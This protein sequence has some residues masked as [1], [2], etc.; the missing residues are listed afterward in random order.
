MENPDQ[1]KRP[2]MTMLAVILAAGFIIGSLIISSTWKYVSRSSITVNV[3]GSASE[4][5]ISDLAVW[6]GSFS[7]EAGT[8]KDAYARL[9]D[10]NSKVTSYLVSKGFPADK[11][12]MSSINT[13][14]IYV[15]DNQGMQTN[16]ISGY[17]LYQDV[18]IESNDV[19][20]IDKLSREITELI[21]EGVEINSLTPS[22][23]YTKLGDLK[24]KMIGQ[25]ALDAKERAKQIAES[26]GNDIGEVRSSRMGVMQITAKN[27][28]EVSDY[29]MNN[30]SSLEKTVTSVVNV[31]FSIE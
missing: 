19:Y 11:I 22:F 3:T 5:I 28:T 15:N 8:L 1:S 14:T 2:N 25:A 24:I 21:N 20:K 23:L 4:N 26:T 9:K 31:S 29:G 13:S 27:S 17:R 18:S 30:T 7:A 10:N 16:Q 6:S 12:V